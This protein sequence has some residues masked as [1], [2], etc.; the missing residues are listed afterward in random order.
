[1]SMLFTQLCNG[2]DAIDATDYRNIMYLL[3]SF[4]WDHDTIHIIFVPF[5]PRIFYVGTSWIKHWFLKEMFTFP[6]TNG[7][8]T[9][10]RHSLYR[11]HSSLHVL[12]RIRWGC[13]CQLWYWVVG[14]CELDCGPSTVLT[15]WV[16][17]KCMV[18]AV[19]PR[20]LSSIGWRSIQ[21]NPRRAEVRD[22]A[23]ALWYDN[24]DVLIIFQALFNLVDFKWISYERI[25]KL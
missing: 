9:F 6:V 7:G 5:L 20:G 15:R 17:V 3:P 2:S 23:E 10:Y 25:G 19:A 24:S 22:Y 14:S 12:L 8:I 13:F 4:V 18:G 1:M 21:I 16:V 11:N